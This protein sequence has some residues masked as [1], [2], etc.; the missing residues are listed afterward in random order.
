M[1]GIAGIVGNGSVEIMIESIRY[2][3]PDQAGYFHDEKTHLGICRL[4]IIDLQTGDQ[5]IFN[6]DGS[7]AIV[8]NGEI[9]NYKE[10]RSSLVAKDH[11]FKTQSDTEVVIHAYEEW[12]ADCLSRFNGQ[13]AFAIHDKK[14]NR[15]FIARDRMGEK[16]LY[17]Y[18]K[19]GRFLFSSEI[20]AI[21]TQ[22]KSS[23]IIPD[24]FWA[25]ESSLI[26]ETLFE[27]IKELPPGCYMLYDGGVPYITKYWSIPE[28]NDSD[29]DEETLAEQLRELVIDSVTIRL[30]SDVPLGI[31][32]SGGLDSAIIACIA[33]P[34]I[35]FSCRFQEG[36]LYDEWF[37]ADLIARHIGCEH[38]TVSPT[39]DE[40]RQKLPEII[41]HLDEPVATASPIGDFAVSREASRRVKV[42]LGGQG[43][44]EC[45]G[46]YGRYLVLMQERRL[47]MEP[48]LRNYLPLMK[49]MWGT[50]FGGDLYSQYFKL[51]CRNECKHPEQHAHTVKNLF[52][53][54]DPI[55]A[56]GFTD[57]HLTLPSLIQ[58][59]DRSSS[60]F[61]VEN[62]NPFLDHRIVEFAY[63]LPPGMKIRGNMT[64][65]LLRK[66]MRGIVPDAILDRKDKKGLVVP[67]RPWLDG[68]LAKWKNELLSSLSKRIE[69]P[70]SSNGEFNR[71]D[72]TRVCLELWFRKFFPDYGV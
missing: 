65:Y 52:N 63:R 61:G 43:S 44:D 33:K 60:A 17:Y 10:I 46:G 55:D 9:F 2:R 20:K 47:A 67:F 45:F 11:R 68:P 6:E 34:D 19:E 71:G 56:M 70:K 40:F 5:P 24:S 58:M 26:G 22:V 1:C 62:R 38:V 3:G 4:S 35:A 36:P 41:Y 29:C 13:F 66:A 7:I 51:L 72:Y 64:K 23:P 53:R 57:I 37:Y 50:G 25:F 27:N 31:A 48:E 8:Y 49:K 39:F 69:I 15:L 32:L 28:Q 14:L 21:L 18:H 42:L 12:G 54:H 59:N 16:P 30:M